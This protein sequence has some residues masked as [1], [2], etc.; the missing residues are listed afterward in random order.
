MKKL[1]FFVAVLLSVCTCLAMCLFVGC[2]DFEL[3]TPTNVQV[4]LNH[5]L[6]WDEVEDARS[7]VVEIKD[8]NGELVDNK[9]EKREYSSL[10]NLAV[11]KYLIRVKAVGSQDGAESDWS[12]AFKFDRP[13]ET[14]CVYTLVN[15]TEYHITG[16]GSASGDIVIE[17]F[18][19]NK[20][21]TAIAENAFKGNGRVT[22]VVLGN[23]IKTIGKNAFYRCENLTSIKIG[24]AHV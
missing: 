6:T 4:D 9:K 23:Q 15:N 8:E 1:K 16:A 20:P 24:R 11:G 10:K 19:R 14:G 13:Y 7:Y 17:D 2:K 3:S 21:V 22:S 12:A 18:Y 5:K